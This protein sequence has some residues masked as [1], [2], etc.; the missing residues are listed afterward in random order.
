MLFDLDGTLADT[1]PDLAAA[2]NAAIAEHGYPPLPPRRYRAAITGGGLGMILTAIGAATD[3]ERAQ[4]IRRRF[5]AHYARRIAV[6]TRLFPG[7]DAV[8][9]ELRARGI[10]WGIVT[11]KPQ[12][13]THR[14][15][16]ALGMTGCASCVVCGDTLAHAKPHPEP[17]LHACRTLA[18]D[19]ARCLFVGDAPTDVAAGRGAAVRTLVALYGYLPEGADAT[20]WGAQGYLAQPSDLLEWL[21]S[22]ERG[23]S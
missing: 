9:R 12:A 5:L 17:I 6:R 2:V 18:A 4:Q 13:L 11:N 14:L 22:R 16:D 15:L 10:A 19:P 23:N 3:P 20:R 21:D 8:L 1:L 7:V